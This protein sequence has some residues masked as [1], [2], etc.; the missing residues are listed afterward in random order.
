MDK[1]FLRFPGAILTSVLVAMILTML[2]LSS[3]LLVWR[4]DWIALT[5][6][7][8]A[9][10]MPKRISL[11]L[12]WFTGL[13]MDVLSGAI[14]GQ[15]ALGFTLVLYMAL[16]LSERINPRIIWQQVFMI[17]IILGVYLLINLWILGV[18]GNTPYSWNYW[19]PLF[20]SIF[21]WP[22][23]HHLLSVFKVTRKHL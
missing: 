15:Y 23:V 12:A 8:W 2:P 1:V 14:L 5:F 7:H 13:L 11:A 10:I 18:T 6:I 20:S 17:F 4:P 22:M 19:L 16:R 9:I 3:G 21:V